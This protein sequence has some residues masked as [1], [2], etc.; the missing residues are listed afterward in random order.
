M[1]RD[2]KEPNRAYW[3]LLHRR[4]CLVPTLR[5]WFM[6]ALGLGALALG[7]I[8]G[9]HPFLAV[10]DSVP[11]GMLVVEGWV[12]DHMLEA[13]IAEFKRNHYARL[14]VTGIPLQKGAPLS[15]Y[16]DYANL[17]AAILIRLGMSTNEVQAVPTGN[18]RRDRTYAT[19]LT[20]KHWLSEHGI[21]TTKVNL[22]TGAPHARRSRLM[23][24]KALGSEVEVGVIAIP[25]DDYDE[26]K[27]WHSSQ[28]VRVIIGEALAYTY[29]RLLFHPSG[30]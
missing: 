2:L 1:G 18:T 29:A 26:K 13:A 23:F 17:G 10:T 4:Q 20:L 7:V 24:E 19:A 11:G 15:E 3:G 5:G 22:I 30:E 6:L 12:P 25:A 21:A 28:G 16:K 27:W 14:F 9:L 8:R